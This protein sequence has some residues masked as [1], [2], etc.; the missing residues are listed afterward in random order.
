[1]R[2]VLVLG[3]VMTKGE[4]DVTLLLLTENKEEKGVARRRLQLGEVGASHG[5]ELFLNATQ[6]GLSQIELGMV[7]I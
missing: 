5:I 7:W 6:L 1:M 2:F 3:C 4:E